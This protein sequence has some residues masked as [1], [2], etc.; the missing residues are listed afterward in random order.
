MTGKETAILTAIKTALG[1]ITAANFVGEYPFDVQ[2]LGNRYPA[3]L[4]E[5]GDES[6]DEDISQNGTL[7]ISYEI[8]VH[9]HIQDPKS[10]LA[11]LVT[12]QTSV[13]NAVTGITWGVTTP[14]P[15][16]CIEYINIVKGDEEN[17]G[18]YLHTGSN[19]HITKR[20]VNFVV[21][22]RDLR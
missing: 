6:N 17:F 8:A 12:L 4:V 16:D 1:T 13:I 5:S 9:I 22:F 20:T 10:R 2:L 7:F 18:D 15:A 21:H 3:L 11:D 14:T 19:D